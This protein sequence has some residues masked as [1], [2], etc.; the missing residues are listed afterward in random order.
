MLCKISNTASLH[1]IVP[2]IASVIQ[3]QLFINYRNIY[4]ESLLTK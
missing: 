4:G 2:M 3:L 1:D